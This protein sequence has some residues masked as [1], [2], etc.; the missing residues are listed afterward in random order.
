L[1]QTIE[2]T[3]NAYGLGGSIFDP[4]ANAVAAIRYIL[5]RYGSIFNIAS[6]RGGTSFVGG[7][8]TG[9]DFVPRT[10]L[11]LIHKGEAVIPA[12]ENRRGRGTH[13]ELHFHEQRSIPAPR[14]MVDALQDVDF[15]YGGAR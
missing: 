11:A 2:P 7:Y 13:Y 6:Y 3:F 1:F 10:G 14:Q 15:L 12:D 9:T 5:A 4:V 8:E